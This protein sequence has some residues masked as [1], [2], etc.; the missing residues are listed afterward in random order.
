[1][2]IFLSSFTAWPQCHRRKWSLNQTCRRCRQTPWRP[3]SWPSQWAPQGGPCENSFEN[4]SNFLLHPPWNSNYHHFIHNWTKACSVN[5]HKL[6]KRLLHILSRTSE[7]SQQYWGSILG[8]SVNQFHLQC[9]VYLQLASLLY[10][11]EWCDSRCHDHARA[12]NVDPD[13]ICTFLAINRLGEV[14]QGSLRSTIGTQFALASTRIWA[15]DY[16]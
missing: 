10:I 2:W 5:F 16:N 7:H 14:I 13:T 11:Y 3:W 6:K 9:L 1:M 4:L 8:L 15:Y 12:K